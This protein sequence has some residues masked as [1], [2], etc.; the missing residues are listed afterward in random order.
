MAGRIHL[1]REREFVFQYLSISLERIQ[2]GVPNKRTFPSGRGPREAP[3]GQPRAK[4]A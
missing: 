1:Q 3:Q 4:D 2:L